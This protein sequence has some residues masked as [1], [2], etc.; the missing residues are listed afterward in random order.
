MLYAF[1]TNCG[2]LGMSAYAANIS[3][4]DGATQD[5]GE[6][7]VPGVP[8]RRV[9]IGGQTALQAI[10]ASVWRG[11]DTSALVS[12]S[13]SITSRLFMGAVDRVGWAGLAGTAEYEIVPGNPGKPAVYG[14]NKQAE[15]FLAHLRRLGWIER[16]V[17]GRYGLTLLGEAL[18]KSD[19][20]EGRRKRTHVGEPPMVE[21]H[22]S[23]C[24]GCWMI[25][26]AASSASQTTSRSPSV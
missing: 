6:P 22:E 1:R 3:T 12:L 20:M 4:G 13:D 14:P 24:V 16:D 15:K 26:C 25:S 21:R 11:M 8:E 7:A 10:A 5:L 2:G 19:A 9:Q 23:G 18:M 17:R